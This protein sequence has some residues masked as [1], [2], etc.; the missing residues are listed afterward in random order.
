MVGVPGPET[1]PIAIQLR[2]IGIQIHD[3]VVRWLAPLLRL[4]TKMPAAQLTPLS[5]DDRRTLI[6]WPS[7]PVTDR[8]SRP[9]T[10]SVEGNVGSGKSTFLQHFQG[11]DGVHIIEEPL[12]KWCNVNGHNLLDKLYQ[13][14]K[15]WSFLFQS[16][17]QLTRL[18]VHLDATPCRVKFIERSLQS[19]RFCFVESALES[20]T[21]EAPEHAVLA[22]YY[23]RSAAWFDIG[24]DLIVYLRT[25]PEV[26]FERV[27]R[28]ARAEE[29]PVTLD[30][31]RQLHCWHQRWLMGERPAHWPRVV[32]IDADQEL[33]RLLPLYDSI[34]ARIM[35][36]VV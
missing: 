31:L 34:H 7:Q 3:D 24:V 30:Y 4:R 26:A 33:Q 11:M 32:V 8:P 9:F 23:S 28:R 20:G 6:D 12:E 25:S 10:V 29:A 36:D 1:V 2:K 17:V 15:R 16:Y 18:Q 22:E 27:V 21:L 13:D 19:N 14:P 5:V 35:D